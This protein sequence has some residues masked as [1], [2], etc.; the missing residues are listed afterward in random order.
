[1]RHFVRVV[2]SARRH[3][4]GGLG[5]VRLELMRVA[6]AAGLCSLLPCGGAS[7]ED[8]TPAHIKAVTLAV[9]GKSIEANG[10]KTNN[11]PTS[12]SIMPKRASAS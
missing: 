6:V 2:D 5:S 3:S 11:W 7:A 8:L 12:V 10:A 1:M 9:D 4:A